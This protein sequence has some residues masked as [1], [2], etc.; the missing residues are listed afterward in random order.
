MKH[1]LKGQIFKFVRISVQV[2]RVFG[3]YAVLFIT[4]L[5]VLYLWRCSH[6]TAFTLC[7]T[8]SYTFEF[9]SNIYFMWW[10][11]ALRGTPNVE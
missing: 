5:F 3:L 8:I 2:N 1:V 11:L 6:C 4:E 9:S 7:T 10:G